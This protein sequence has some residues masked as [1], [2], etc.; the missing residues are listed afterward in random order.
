MSL[1]SW[2]DD[3]HIRESELAAMLAGKPIKQTSGKD[4]LARWLRFDLNTATIKPPDG[5]AY[6]IE[7]IMI[8]TSTAPVTDISLE[9][10]VTQEI[11]EFG[12]GS[13][14]SSFNY[15]D[16]ITAAEHGSYYLNM[17]RNGSYV[18]KV[19]ASQVTI[20]LPIPFE[21]LYGTQTMEI[22]CS[23]ADSVEGLLLYR[24]LEMI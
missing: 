17:V 7:A 5:T 9:I 2:L 3:A 4:P 6:D 13:A 14:I 23:G 11:A 16:L 18:R 20:I 15:T 10:D 1:S 21:L 12:P 24:E 19:N 22:S 8:Y